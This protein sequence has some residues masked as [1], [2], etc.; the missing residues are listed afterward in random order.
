M[1]SLIGIPLILSIIN[2]TINETAYFFTN[3]TNI[4]NFDE[5]TTIENRLD[6]LEAIRKDL[7]GKKLKIGTIEDY[8][9][10]YTVDLGNGTYEG[11]GVS[12]ELIK[13]LSKKFNFTYEI[14]KPKENKIGS[15]LDFENS[16]IELVNKSVS[17]F[18]IFI[19][20]QPI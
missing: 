8:P 5:A 17:I 14:I 18:I 10:S 2:T 13:F 15:S 9:L 3:E 11:H 16:L 12:F 6:K 7:N 19:L 1:D 20:I 4:E